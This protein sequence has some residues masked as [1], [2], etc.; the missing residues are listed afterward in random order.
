M[1][2]CRI[3]EGLGNQL[4]QFAAG[5][6]FSQRLAAPLSLDREW[7]NNPS[8]PSGRKYQLDRFCIPMCSLFDDKSYAIINQHNSLK[9]NL[10]NLAKAVY[11]RKQLFFVSRLAE[12]SNLK[13]DSRFFEFNSDLGRPIYVNGYWQ[14]PKY[15]EKF[16]S[17]LQ[18]F[19]LLKNRSPRLRE[20]IQKIQVTQG[21]S[22]HIRRGDLVKDE[23]IRRLLGVCTIDYYE[24]ALSAMEDTHQLSDVY[25]FSDD[26]SWAKSMLKCNRRRHFVSD[27]ELT[28]V[29]ELEAMRFCAAHIIAN[30]TFSWW[31]AWLSGSKTVIIPRSDYWGRD[32]A[33][34]LAKILPQGWVAV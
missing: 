13:I 28:D 6:S 14:S 26:P 23:R 17:D 11:S 22:L 30:S 25:V 19:F 32:G 34:R 15:F 20:L 31:G 4:F 1:V 29:E 16:K 7:F 18:A 21:L 10:K 5:Y 33:K 24:K 9:S 3:A 8:R 2:I 27:Y 12:Q